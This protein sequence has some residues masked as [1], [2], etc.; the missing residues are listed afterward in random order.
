MSEDVRS[1][2]TLNSSSTA[3]GNQFYS[4]TLNTDP[5]KDDSSMKCTETWITN[6]N[7][8]PRSNGQICQE[9]SRKE[10][11]IDKN[12]DFAQKCRKAIRE[13]MINGGNDALISSR[14]NEL[15]SYEAKIAESEAALITIGP[16]PVI[17]CTKHHEAIKDVEM[18]VTSQLVDSS[19]PDFQTV[20]PKHSEKIRSLK[21]KSPIITTNRFQNLAELEDKE[22]P[23]IAIPAI[24]LKLDDDYNL[25]LQEIN[26]KF[27]NTENSYDRENIRILPQT[28]DDREN[29][30]KFLNE[31]NKEFVTSEAP[32][33]GPLKIVVKGLPPNHDKEKISQELVKNNFQPAASW[34]L[35]SH[36]SST[37][38]GPHDQLFNQTSPNKLIPFKQVLRPILTYAA[39][40]WRPAAPSNRKKVQILQ[41]KLLRII[42][43]APWFIRN[44][45]I[46]SDLQIESIEDHIQKLSR[47]FFS[48]IVDHPNN[49]IADQTDYT[50]FNG[51]YRYPYATTKWSLPLKPP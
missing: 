33:N 45:V 7:K 48:G 13:I 30:I 26:R 27:P 36:R 44:S 22:N 35:P 24:N 9:I 17:S 40:T 31:N 3:F 39:P 21:P 43:N 51:R 10:V 37:L 2:S 11:I 50:E 23:K 20:S 32:K 46:H 29:I 18:H 8:Q 28:L 19:P 38:I 5:V 4:S 14:T 1:R 49:L 25:T 12:Q 15:L 16:C 42:A 6:Y 34:I 47:K 41:N